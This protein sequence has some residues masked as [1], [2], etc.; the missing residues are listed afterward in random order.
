PNEWFAHP[1]RPALSKP[2]AQGGELDMAAKQLREMFTRGADVVAKLRAL[3]SLHV[4]GRADEAFLKTQLQH[5]NEHV[6]AWAVRLLT[7]NWPIDTVLSQ[8]PANR[9][10]A[11]EPRLMSEF[12]SL[13]HKDAS[14]LV[15][16]ALA[17][18]LQR[19]PVAK[20]A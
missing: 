12:V 1:A 7:D 17:S 11:V 16:L 20:R 19:L 3:W 18:T 9:P 8:R 2:A 6:R 15:R 14:G 5:P 10:E 13:A 4:I